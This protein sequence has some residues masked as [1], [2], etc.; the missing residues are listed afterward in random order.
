[1]LEEEVV[2]VKAL[3][4]KEMEELVEAEMVVKMRD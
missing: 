1:M 4:M 3:V 2:L